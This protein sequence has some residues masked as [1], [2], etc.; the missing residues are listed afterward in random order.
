MKIVLFGGSGM[1]GSRIAKEALD[2]GHQVTAVGR[3]PAKIELKHPA[4]QTAKGDV[5]DPASITAIALG[6]D[7]AI[8]AYSPGHPGDPRNLVKA[9][10]A[11]LAGLKPAG[12]KR[13]LVVGGAG[14]LEVKPGLRLVDTPEFP[15]AWKPVALAH[16][17]ALQ[18]FRGEKTLE[19]SYLSPA[20]FI[21][22]GERTGKY[23]LGG[24]QLVI[25]AKGESRISAEDY[26]VAVLDELERPRHVRA[27]FTA[28]Y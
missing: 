7:A 20:A 2:R 5:L 24:E 27:R 3:E 6:H 10:Q 4:L 12:V 13:L 26:A 14:S 11:L 19:W 8:S 22:P 25:D 18:V 16:A 9:A 21:A 23:R 1:I 17:D 28:A 15:A